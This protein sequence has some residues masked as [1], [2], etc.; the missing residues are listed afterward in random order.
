MLVSGQ[1]LYLGIEYFTY[2]DGNFSSLYN[3]FENINIHYLENIKTLLL[4][5][6]IY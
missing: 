6:Y 3:I 1:N 5:S 4:S 2:Q